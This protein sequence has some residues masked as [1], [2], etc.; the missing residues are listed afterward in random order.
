MNRKLANFNFLFPKMFPTVVTPN[1]AIAVFLII[2]LLSIYF[3]LCLDPSTYDV[4][5][6]HTFMV[7]FIALGSIIT[8]LFYFSLVEIQQQNH[9]R[10]LIHESSSISDIMFNQILPAIRQSNKIIPHF[11]LSLF[12]LIKWGHISPDENTLETSVEKYLLSNYIFSVWQEVIRHSEFLSCSQ[13]S[14]IS[15]FLQYANSDQLLHQW[16]LHHVNYEITT[17]RFGNLLFYY[18][19]KYLPRTGSDFNKLAKKFTKDPIYLDLVRYLSV[20]T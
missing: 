5:R 7:V 1:I 8:F 9:R 18:T 10:N 15:Q 13:D 3:S 17:Q 20:R 16:E 12:P 19:N 6:V 4:S 14:Y 11:T 2:I